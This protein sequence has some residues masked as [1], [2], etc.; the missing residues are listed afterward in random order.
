MDP[1]S[2]MIAHAAV[3]L[4]PI[5]DPRFAEAFDRYADARVVLLGE[6]SHG[7]SEFYRARAAITRRLIERHGFNIVAVEA[8]WPD[9]AALNRRVRGL[10]AREEDAQAFERF[11]HWM[12]RNREVEA[13]LE[14]MTAWN[15]GKVDGGQAGFYG[16]DLYNLGGSM[17][18]V[19]DYL[20]V[21]D[22]EGA[23]DARERYGCLL[24]WSRDPAR[25]GQLAMREGHA[26]CEEGVL[27]MLRDMLNKRLERD[28]EA[29][30]DA[31]ANARLVA[32]AE[33]YYRVMYH[34]AAE[35]WNLRDSHMFETLCQVLEGAGCGREGGRVGAQ[36]PYRRRALYRHGLV[37]RRA[38]YRAA[39]A[40]A[41]QQG[42]GADRL[43]NAHRNGGGGG[44]LGRAV[45]DQN[46]QAVDARKHRAALPRCGRG[47]VPAGPARRG[48][49][50][51][52][53]AE[54]AAAG[55]L[56]RRH[57]PPADRA[58]EPLCGKQPVAAV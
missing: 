8:D 23:D 3:P 32:N 5:D 10:P 6:A 13:L 57:L 48:R 51:A 27:A 33:A 2:Q 16:L 1:I 15:R 53:R 49:G 54:R 40:T 55:A 58:V 30:L 39:G 14:W 35:S 46:G 17:R 26:A 20:D 47:A 52:E 45:A 4:P 9:A 12:W 29:L 19:I 50:V 21:H 56:Y 37:A 36:Q 38:Q 11:P 41:V 7:T 24:P 28:D 42:G 31:Q 44:R 43:R 25:Y 22:P 34:G 18:A